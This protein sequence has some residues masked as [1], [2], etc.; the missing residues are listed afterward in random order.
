MP[1][2]FCV[3]LL[4]YIMVI[5]MNYIQYTHN[6]IIVITSDVKQLMFNRQ[7]INA[8]INETRTTVSLFCIIVCCFAFKQHPA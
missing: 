4:L 8:K 2:L 5:I 6:I 7:N 3:I 1:M